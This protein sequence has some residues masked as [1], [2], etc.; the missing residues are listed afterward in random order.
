MMRSIVVGLAVLLAGWTAQAAPLPATPEI[1]ARIVRKDLAYP[2]I[3]VAFPGGVT[4]LPDVVYSSPDGYR[5]LKL[6]LYLPP[7]AFKDRGPRPVVVYIHGGGWLAGSGRLNGAFVDWPRV[8]ASL[9]TKGYVVAAISFRQSS[10][11]PFPAAVQDV[12]TAIQWLRGSA[13]LYNIDKRRF[14]TWGVSSGGQLAALAGVSCGAANLNSLWGPAESDC[15]Q[16]A[17]GWY[18][19][20]DFP[21]LYAAFPMESP[22]TNPYFGC[23]QTC[24][25]QH[26]RAPSPTAYV[27]RYDPPILLVHGDRDPVVPISQARM[28]D[29]ALTAA[30]AKSRL[31]EVPGAAHAWLSASPEATRDNSLK[32]LRLTFDFFDEIIGDPPKP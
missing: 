3:E 29:A 5:P 30:G 1:A 24:T 10:E 11:A 20:F 23:P 21:A 6:D 22:T 28:F 13:E 31:I 19:V 8:L 27:D 7:M 16:G 9:A 17:V 2:R 26:L 12:K 4:G 14:M 25:A 15:V 18:G 32:A